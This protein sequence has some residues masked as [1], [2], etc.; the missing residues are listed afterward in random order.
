MGAGTAHAH[1]F[2]GRYDEAA[3]W[4]AMALQDDPDVQFGLRVA[5]ASNAMAGRPEQAHK[6][7]ARLR[8]LSPTLRISNLKDV[9]PLIGGAQN[10]LRNLRG[11]CAARCPQ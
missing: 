2:L 11:C 8:Q 9:L 5:A 3:S 10:P 1:F 7:M 4:A 6:A